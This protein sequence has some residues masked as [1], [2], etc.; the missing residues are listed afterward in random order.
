MSDIALLNRD[1]FRFID[2][3]PRAAAEA[4]DFFYKSE[5]EKFLSALQVREPESIAIVA[6]S[7]SQLES[8]LRRFLLLSDVVVFNVAT[9][10]TEPQPM[11]LPVPDDLVNPILGVNSIIDSESMKP[12]FPKPV[13]LYQAMMTMHAVGKAGESASDFLGFEW[14]RTG[15]EWRRTMYSRTSE[16]YKNDAKEACHIAVGAGLLYPKSTC[17]WLLKQARPLLEAGALSFAPFLR[18]PPDAWGNAE[19]IHKA[20]FTHANVGTTTVQLGDTIRLQALVELEIPFL[21]GIP[22]PLLANILQDERES[23]LSFRAA[24]SRLIRAAQK[25]ASEPEMLKEV[26]AIRRDQIDPE[27]AKLETLSKRVSQMRALRAAGCLLGSAAI[28]LLSALGVPPATLLLP[29]A[30]SVAA[31]LYELA[32]RIEEQQKQRDNPM[33]FLWHLK[34]STN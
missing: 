27:I 33:Y 4:I 22:L 25:A 18:V 7:E 21:D 30:G 19:S 6:S 11:L 8:Q 32:R 17:E 23:L 15:H 1:L 5:Y 20:H 14:G 24:L 28:C 2:K 26:R 31:N 16:S 3:F 29:A 12:R 10:S 13:E 34:K 9:Y